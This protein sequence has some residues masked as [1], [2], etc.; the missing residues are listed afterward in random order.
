[1]GLGTDIVEETAEAATK[2]LAK[3]AVEKA[4][5]EA[6][7]KAAQKAAADA[8][9][10]AAKKAAAKE[11]RDAALR[12]AADRARAAVKANKEKAAAEMLKKNEADLAKALAEGTD[13]A[14]VDSLKKVGK[15]AKNMSDEALEETGK[16]SSKMGAAQFAGAMA[17]I[18]LTVAQGVLAMQGASNNGKTYRVVTIT[19]SGNDVTCT[20]TP[21]IEPNGIVV[22]DS[23]TFSNTMT[24]LDGNTYT[25]TKTSGSHG[26][27]KFTAGAPVAEAK[28]GSF[29]L[30]T[31][32]AN[33]LRGQTIGNITG[34]LDSMSDKINSFFS[35]YGWV[36]GVVLAII[37]LLAIVVP[38]ILK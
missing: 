20:Y 10:A 2:R 13:D 36:I 19:P 3:E 12:S 14:V 15:N 16:R 28:V 4:A 18:G 9:Q 7:Q 1:M 17:A 11:S 34:G 22:N 25:I 35:S 29:V 23:I 32:F 31:S 38:M 24:I 37:L 21:S 26:T 6:A 5:A 30:H 33:Q 27:V 8:A